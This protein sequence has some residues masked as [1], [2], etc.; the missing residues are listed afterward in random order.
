M[1]IPQIEPVT[2]L[3]RD[4]R[5]V[6]GKLEEGPVFLA[7]RSRPAA[8]L[9]SVGD[10]KEMLDRLEYLEDLAEVYKGKWLLAT[11]QESMTRLSDEE[12]T[13]WAGESDAVLA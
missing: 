4:Y 12:T 5:A 13:E 2:S 10:Y 6:F 11:G 9:L 7:Q 8:V 1:G 3:S